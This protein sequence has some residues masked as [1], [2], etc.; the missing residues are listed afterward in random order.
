MQKSRA[1]GL[2]FITVLVDMLGIGIAIP[3]VPFLAES[4]GGSAVT[5]GLLATVYAA[6]QLVSVPIIGAL[7]DRFGRRPLLLLAVLI[8]AIAHFL[9]AFA[10]GLALLFLA[11]LLDGITG[12]SVVAAQA[13]I[14]DISKPEERAKNFGLLGA[15]F[16]LGFI[17]GPALGGLLSSVSLQT[18]ALVAGVLSLLNLALAFALLPES[19]PAERRTTARLTLATFNPFASFGRVFRLP[20]VGMLLLVIFLFNVPFV[21]LQSNFPLFSEARLGWGPGENAV[22]FTVIGIVIAVAQGALIGQLVTR[23]GERRLALVGLVGQVLAFVALAALAV[24]WQLYMV[25]IAFAFTNA[26]VG[27]SL[28]GLLSN[29]A[30]DQEQGV[31]LGVAQSITSLAQMVG[32]LWAGFTFSYLAPGA[33]Y[34]TGAIWFGLALL[35]LAAAGLVAKPAMPSEARG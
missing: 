33:P 35:G 16:G 23:Y 8:T 28:T 26:L 6:V 19:L 9:F 3:V 15:A 10:D 18:P 27:P 5:V 4:F 11:R 12:G 21:G 22:L 2:I 7:S 24:G 25:M 1:L 34:W 32:P 14:A 30:T 13:Y 31:V 17:L 20:G 29:S